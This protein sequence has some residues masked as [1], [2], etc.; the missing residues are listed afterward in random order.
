MRF[1]AKIALISWAWLATGLFAAA[2]MT[3]SRHRAGAAFLV[4]YTVLAFAMAAIQFLSCFCI[5]WDITP[6]AL[7]EQRLW[8]R[9]TIPWQEIT[10]VVSWPREN[11]ASDYLEIYFYRPAPLSANGSVIASPAERAQFLSAI[12]EHAPQARIQLGTST[13][14]VPAR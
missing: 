12:R 6:E 13:S 3:S 2:L 10:E 14:P 7:C 1:R 4:V 9:R 8:A 11:R 5:W